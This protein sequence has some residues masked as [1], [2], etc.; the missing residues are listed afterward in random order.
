VLPNDQFKEAP[1]ET[2]LLEYKQFL[3]DGLAVETLTM[4]PYISKYGSFY[5]V[6]T[7]NVFVPVLTIQALWHETSNL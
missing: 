1:C 6:V 7:D 5:E 4:A 3:E 2:L